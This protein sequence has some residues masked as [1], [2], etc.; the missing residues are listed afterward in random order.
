MTS[1]IICTS[2]SAADFVYYESYLAPRFLEYSSYWY[3]VSGGIA[4]GQDGMTLASARNAVWD[5]VSLYLLTRRL[6]F[7]KPA[8]G[9]ALRSLFAEVAEDPSMVAEFDALLLANPQTHDE[10]VVFAESCLRFADDRL[11]LRAWREFYGSLSTPELYGRYH[12]RIL[13]LGRMAGEIGVTLPRSV[14][15]VM[16][17][18]RIRTEVQ[19][20]VAGALAEQ[21]VGPQ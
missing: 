10:T 18:I 9:P 21:A 3:D 4:G 7:Q 13:D 1:P 11:G 12:Q 20:R 6:V 17:G 14:E 8:P 15:A 5:G 19:R 2:S 16:E